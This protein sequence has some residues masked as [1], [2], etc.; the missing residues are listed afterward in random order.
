MSLLGGERFFRDNWR[1]RRQ[2][3]TAEEVDHNRT[4]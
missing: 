2:V 3:L 4:A 1:E